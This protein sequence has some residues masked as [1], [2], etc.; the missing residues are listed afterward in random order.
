MQEHLSSFVLCICHHCEVF[1]WKSHRQL[2]CASRLWPA[3]PS[4]ERI[5]EVVSDFYLFVPHLL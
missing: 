1:L 4:W 3:S 2:T 5:S